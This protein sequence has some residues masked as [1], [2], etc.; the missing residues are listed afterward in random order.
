[1]DAVD[2]GAFAVGLGAVELVAEVPGQVS[3]PLLDLLQRHVTVQVPLPETEQVQ[4]GTV[5]EEEPGHAAL[6]PRI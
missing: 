5:D 3:C 2:E 1:M 4:I 6:F